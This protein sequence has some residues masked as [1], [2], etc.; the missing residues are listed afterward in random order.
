VRGVEELVDE[1]EVGGVGFE[2]EEARVKGDR[3]VKEL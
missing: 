3:S 1:G 2:N